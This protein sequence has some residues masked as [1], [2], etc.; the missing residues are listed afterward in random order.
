MGQSAADRVSAAARKVYEIASSYA[1]PR[2]ILVADTKMEFGVALNGD[3]REAALVLG[4]EVLQHG[5]FRSC[6]LQGHHAAAWRRG[7]LSVAAA[8]IS[9]RC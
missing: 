7:V 1:E 9:C 4:D 2:G 5:A 8:R 3:L 6:C